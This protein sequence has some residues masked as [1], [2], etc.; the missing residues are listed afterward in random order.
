MSMPK[1][2]DI[3]PEITL[4]R[5]EAINLLLTSIA[6]EEIGL[7]HI[8]NAE[9]EKIQRF[10]KDH[11]TELDDILSINRSVEIML[12]NVIKKQMLLQFKL[13]D[14]LRL[15]ECEQEECE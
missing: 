13:E 5:K 3:T 10:V 4:N 9:G 2:P 11:H 6:L 7:S 15:E 1:V 12:R 8:I 14:I